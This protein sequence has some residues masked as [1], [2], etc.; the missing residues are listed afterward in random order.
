V[1]AGYQKVG[2]GLQQSPRLTTYAVD[3]KHTKARDAKHVAGLG[4]LTRAI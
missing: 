1:V 2:D 3:G 4:L